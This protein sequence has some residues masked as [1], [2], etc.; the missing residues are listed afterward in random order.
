MSPN[1]RAVAPSAALLQQTA[2][3]DLLQGLD[4]FAARRCLAV[5]LE[6]L[7]LHPSRATTRA[8]QDAALLAAAASLGLSLGTRARRQGALRRF[9]RLEGLRRA[10]ELLMLGGALPELVAEGLGGLTL[11]GLEHAAGLW[12]SGR[13][14]VVVGAHVG[15]MAAYVPG[16][17]FG[18]AR[19]ALRPALLAVLHAP[20]H[21]AVE[22]RLA[23]LAALAGGAL[24]CRVKVPGDEL[25]LLRSL[26]RAV[27][28]GVWVMMQMDALG[29]GGRAE[30]LPFPGGPLCLPALWGAVRLAA[31]FGAALL[32]V[33]ALRVG[34]RGLRLRIEAPLA[35][36]GPA[37]RIR[38]AS[39]P[40]LRVAAVGLAEQLAR[41]V[42]ADPCD[43]ALLPE[44][45]RLRPRRAA[46]AP[47]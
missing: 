6:E 35:A 2:L 34:A 11:E 45:E 8:P 38:R 37:E 23:A 7:E 26:H 41:W 13:P 21:P 17:A 40:R 32:P 46:T 33:R 3:W 36:W 1:S 15:P 20:S 29:G 43:W 16:L 25:G 22:E 9:R 14:V 24:R 44:L 42:L 31:R 30:P 28:A 39:D 27:A 10:E 18:L 47:R 12:R 5:W 19:A 4:P